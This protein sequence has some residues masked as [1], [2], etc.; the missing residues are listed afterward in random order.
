[1]SRCRVSMDGLDEQTY[2]NA[3]GSHD[4]AALSGE[5]MVFVEYG[6]TDCDSVFDIDPSGTTH[7]I[8]ESQ[9]IVGSK[10]HGNAIR[11]S[12]KE[13]ILTYSDRY[14]D[15]IAMTLDGQI[16]WRLAELVPGG[17]ASWGGAQHGHQLLDS[18]L[19]IFAN[20]GMSISES[21]A[22]EFDLAGNELRRF[23]SGLRSGIMGDV[24]RLP[25]GNTWVTY[26]TRGKIQ[27]YD[28]SGNVVFE[29]DA[30]G[31]VI[32]YS[33]WRDSLYGPPP[34]STL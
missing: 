21:A 17:N 28:E 7:E 19:L 26:S 16:L 24:Q 9:G 27:E 13:N 8:F 1:V 20:D 14:E 2:P 23:H 31:D 5:T 30:G 29:V 32:G 10:C 33:M 18:S 6:E 11:Y 25:G 4:I 15:L 12:A 3:L 22:I 34:V